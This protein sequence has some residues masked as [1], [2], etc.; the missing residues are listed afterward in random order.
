MLCKWLNNDLMHD[1][2]YSRHDPNWGAIDGDVAGGSFGRE[3]E[4]RDARMTVALLHRAFEAVGFWLNRT[5]Q[6]K[7]RIAIGELELVLFPKDNLPLTK[8]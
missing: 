3:I 1:R 5:K 7:D 8:G 6:S 2:R 4:E